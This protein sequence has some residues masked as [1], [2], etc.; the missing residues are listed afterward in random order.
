M[1]NLE[2]DGK[3]IKAR[4]G[5][6]V[7]EAADDAGI[8]I[9]R[10]CYHKKLSIAA[11]CRMC[12]VEIEKVGKAVP[13]CATPVTDG[14]K[15][16]TR[17]PKAIDAQK[18]VMEFLLI[19]HPLDCPIC[20]QGGE[21]ELQD[22]AMGYGGDVSKYAENK[23]VVENKDFGPLISGDMTR[24]IHCTRCVR[25]GDEV[26]GVRELGAIGRG[27]HMEIGTYVKHSLKSEMSGN[28]IDLCP[29]GALTSKPFRFKARAWEISQRE[30]VAPHDCLGSNILAHIFH[31][32][33]VRVVPKEN[34]AINETWLADRDRFSYEGIHSDQRLTTPMIKV[35]GEWREADW[36][37]ALEKVVTGIQAII[38]EKGADA[39]GAIATPSSTVE[40][41]Y[42]LQKLMRGLGSGN[43]DHRLMQTDFSDQDDAPVYP[44]LGQSIE[45]IEN[46]DAILLIGSN[47]RQDQPIAGHRLRKAAMRG[48]LISC[49]NPLDYDFNFPLAARQIVR[50][51]KMV[52]NLA[53]V[54]KALLEQVGGTDAEGLTAL[55]TEVT[56]EPVHSEM[57]RQ[58]K[59]AQQASLILGHD[60]LA[61][62]D[63]STLR[64]LAQQIANMSGASFGYL[65]DG[66]NTAGACLAG[67]LPHRNAG[68]A[69]ADVT[70][71]DLSA[72]LDAGLGAYLLLGVEP[73]SDCIQSQKMLSTLKAASIVVSL[74]AYKNDAALDYA[75][76]LLPVSLFTE[77][78]GSFINAEG[79]W[80]SF[81]GITEPKGEARPAWK[82]IRV[83]GNLFSVDGFDY[84]HSQDVCD[85][86]KQLT[87]A[88]TQDNTMPWRCPTALPK[89][90]EGIEML[91]VRNMYQGD[92]IQRHADCL[93]VVETGDDSAVRMNAN[94]ATEQG[95][96]Q[97][98][99]V[100]VQTAGIELTLPVII[101][102]RVADN[103]VLLAASDFAA[104]MGSAD[105]NIVML[106]QA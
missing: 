48:A 23:R 101:D 17:S 86:L 84:I 25:F 81:A 29:V 39:V 33:V 64:A 9:P 13:A 3:T 54:L 27:E 31:N 42:L 38:K 91:A 52:E 97:G 21:C 22:I 10:F 45:D 94:L 92:A 78:S 50:P 6:M 59:Q 41:L 49:I 71:K 55:I 85:E 57:A 73:E 70:G 14:M 44:S 47:I 16:F 7:I 20:D 90:A 11:N 103:S 104:R 68:G 95:F 40:E 2:I 46:Q 30:T 12:L 35:E 69:R 106:S 83:L 87:A 89:A 36:N 8:Y 19:N 82:V 66:A 24:C 32:E 96:A 18:G 67:A 65:T 53:A 72:M 93:Q 4:D 51:G 62:A 56:V 80:Q 75:D 1:A 34:E 102:E 76:V 61:H 79:R 88:I 77:T 26:A 99:Q 100:K 60:A 63:F 105:S 5:A 74:A 37:T 43:I 58:L 28:V 15:I 98:D